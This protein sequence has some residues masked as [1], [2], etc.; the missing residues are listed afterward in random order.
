MITIFSIP[1]GFEGLTGVMQRNSVKSWTLLQPKCE[2]ILLGDDPGTGDVAKEFGAKYIP[3]IERNE[4]GTPLM[5]SGFDLAEKHG[6]HDLLCYVNADIILTSEFIEAVQRV[7]EKTNWFLMTA[8]RW[9]LDLVESL[10]FSDR[11]EADLHQKVAKEGFIRQAP[12]VDFWVFPKGMLNDMPPLAVGRPSVECWSFYKARQ[13]NGDLIDATRAVQSVHQNHD[14]SHSGGP[15]NN[16][17]GVEARRNRNLVGGRKYFFSIKD[18]THILTKEGLERVHDH[19][20][21]W[22]TFR[23]SP[24][25]H[26]SMPLPVRLPAKLLNSALDSSIDMLKKVRNLWTPTAT[27][28]G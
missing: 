14:Y 9:N 15:I 2:V 26:P 18:R 11:W 23:T 25:L 7:K 19:W 3:D 6:S 1:K 17:T 16:G 13:M 12:E 24:V 27:K 5:S 4:L 21:V 10:D 8:R 22:R 20:S 28:Q